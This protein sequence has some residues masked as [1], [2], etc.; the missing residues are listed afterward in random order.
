[1]AKLLLNLGIVCRADVNKAQEIIDYLQNESQI[2][3]IKRSFNKLK[4]L[5]EGINNEE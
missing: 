3:F 1:M 4:I 5:E 2:I